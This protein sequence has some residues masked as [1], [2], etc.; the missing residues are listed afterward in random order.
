M[1]RDQK[2]FVVILCAAA[3]M[4]G[5]LADMFTFQ[6]EDRGLATVNWRYKSGD[7]LLRWSYR[8]FQVSLIQLAA[9]FLSENCGLHI[10]IGFLQISA[11]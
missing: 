5:M 11:K 9:L 6:L 10:S 7:D 4:I 2:Q 1:T 3:Y 8:Q